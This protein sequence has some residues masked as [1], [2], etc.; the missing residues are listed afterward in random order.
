[1]DE[2]APH[3][4]RTHNCAAL[5]AADVGRPA[6]LSGWVHAKRDHGGLLFIDLR[7]HYGMVQLVFPAGSAAFEIAEETRPESVITAT[8]EVVRREGAT[9]NPRLPTG[10]IEI[11][12][13]DIVVQS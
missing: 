5:R 13:A 7:D 4:Y 2:F 3:E 8:G 6:R 9:V 12:V 1:M 11:R 10:E